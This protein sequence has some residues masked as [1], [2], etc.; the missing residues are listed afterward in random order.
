MTRTIDFS[1]IDEL[2]NDCYK[3]LLE[4]YTRYIVFRGGSSSGKS[5]FI[6]QRSIYNVCT[7]PGYNMLVVRAVNKDNHTTTF[8]EFLKCLNAWGIR[9]A[10][11]VNSSNGL[12]EIQFKGNKNKIVFK[13]LNDVE[14]IKSF[15]F[16]TGPLVCVWIEEANEATE[17]D[18]NQLDLRLRGLSAIPKHIILS[19]NPVDVDSWL[20][21]RF[22]D[23]PL[24]KK[25]CKIIETTYKDNK[26]LSDE[27]RQAIERY[28]DIDLYYYTVYALNQWGNRSTAR[29]FHNVV[30]EDFDIKEYQL[31][32]RRFG[33]DFGFNH[34]NALIGTG[35]KDGELYL[36]WEYY[37]KGQLNKEFIDSVLRT[38]LPKDYIIKADSADPDKIAEWN[39]AGYSVYGATKGPNSLMR[40]INYLKSLP[41]IHIHKTNCPNA[42][43]EFP[44][45]K[46]RQLKDGRICDNEIVELNDDTVAAVRYANEEFVEQIAE[47]HFFIKRRTY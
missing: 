9:D 20:K 33:M 39:N 17:D 42:A 6:V 37:R 8:Q 28:K 36:F 3:Q 16:E 34:A 4:D 32:N 47:T 29:V 25:I 27:D 40:G 35:W 21:P 1:N 31:E 30:I 18:F 26:F 22:F 19:F 12:E 38:T 7:V 44:G 10:F 5:F 24:D 14:Q 41:K 45:I 43:R 46:Y 23:N 11:R 15:T 2:I 13:G